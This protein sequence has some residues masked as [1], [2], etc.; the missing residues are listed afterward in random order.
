MG[1]LDRIEHD[2]LL[3]LLRAIPDYDDQQSR[4]LLKRKLPSE[5]LDNIE[6]D[7]APGTHL[8]NIL[9]VV[10]TDLENPPQ[11]GV[12]PILTLVEN[13]KIWAERF[14]YSPVINHI[15]EGLNTL[16]EVLQERATQ[17]IPKI[18]EYLTNALISA[19]PTL[20][21]LELFILFAF[22]WMIEDV[23][24]SNLLEKTSNLVSLAIEEKML[25]N[26]IDMA[27]LS[28]P[29]DPYI[30]AVAVQANRAEPIAPPSVGQSLN[31][32]QIQQLSIALAGAFIFQEFR[33]LTHVVLDKK[34][35]ELS[36]REQL[37][38]A[39]IDLILYCER[40]GTTHKFIK[41]ALDLRPNNHIFNWF[42]G[43]PPA[44]TSEPLLV[45]SST[46]LASPDSWFE[47][48]NAFV[49]EFS[50]SELR[51]FVMKTFGRELD[52]IS[53]GNNLNELVVDLF[54]WT[55]DQGLLNDLLDAAK[56]ARP[57]ELIFQLFPSI[58]SSLV[59]TNKAENHIN[60]EEYFEF[61]KKCLLTFRDILIETFTYSELFQMMYKIG[62]DLET[63]TLGATLNM[64]V[65]DLVTWAERRNLT[66]LLLKSALS[67][68]P[69]NQLL[70]SLAADCL[71]A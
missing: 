35:E 15:L 6:D 34:L 59:N 27:I 30:R 62:Y 10:D 65:L 19:F 20:R 13:A 53:L 8:K 17:Q 21:K 4:R 70:I 46:M 38:D 52:Y 61:S 37:T 16:Y 48:R 28:S 9:R 12:W 23:A 1:L 45:T 64:V 36:L 63:I 31:G 43:H 42:L 41:A 14:H 3:D 54:K 29:H 60:E 56:V 22:D 18:D 68:K 11:D 44:N 39:A 58:P 50:F 32:H 71:S 51:H 57:E 25:V 69:E 24:G 7:G 2:N 26:L 40:T 33:E 47:L 55:I 66:S 5:I 49:R 67:T